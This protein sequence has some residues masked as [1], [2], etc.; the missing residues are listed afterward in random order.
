[1]LDDSGERYVRY[2]PTP[3]ACVDCHAEEP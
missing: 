3:T 2:V 1:V